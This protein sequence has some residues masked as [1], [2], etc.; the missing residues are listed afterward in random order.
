MMN[1]YEDAPVSTKLIGSSPEDFTKQISSRL[2]RKIG[3]SVF[4]SCNLE[5]DR[6][7]IPLV[8]KRLHD[9]IKIIQ[10]HFYN[11]DRS[12]TCSICIKQIHP[13]PSQL[14]AMAQKWEKYV[15]QFFLTKRY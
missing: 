6:I 4:L 15:F 14:L 5:P 3:K 2:T 7:F 12:K 13:I 9:E 10:V 1:R 11:I 8:E